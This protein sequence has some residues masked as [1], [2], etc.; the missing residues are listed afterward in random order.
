MLILDVKS[1]CLLNF[2]RS[3]TCI[4]TIGTYSAEIV[5]Y[6]LKATGS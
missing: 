2:E 1:S 5:V 4:N 3:G 6:N